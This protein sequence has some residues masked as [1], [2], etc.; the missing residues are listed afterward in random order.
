[1]NAENNASNANPNADNANPEDIIIRVENLYKQIGR[2]SCRER[3]FRT[4]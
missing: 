2:A 1:M 4:V 3:V